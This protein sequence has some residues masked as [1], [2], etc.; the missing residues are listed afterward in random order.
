MGK[1]KK[2]P[3]V[4]FKGFSDE[5]EEK[6]IG[7][8]VTEKKRSVELLDDE[9]YELIKVK[10]RNEGVISRGYLKGKDILV[11]NYSQLKAGD[12]IISKR[13][14]VHG[15]TGIVPQELDKAIV[16]NEYL[17][18]GSNEYISTE[19]LT[20]I[21]TLPEMYRKFFLSSYGVDIEKLFFDADDWKKRRVIIPKPSEQK[22]ICSWFRRL[23]QMIKLHQ[24][25]HEKLMSLKKAMLQKMFPQNGATVPEVRF[26]GFS[27][28]WVEKKLGQVGKTQSGIG[29]PEPEQGGKDGLPFFKISDMGNHGNEHVMKNAKNYVNKE[30]VARKRWNPITQVP[31]II[32]AKVG[33]A[34]LLNRKRMVQSP[35]LID[36]NTM[37]YLFDKSWDSNFGRA[38]F[39]TIYLPKYAQ[40]GALPSYNGTFIENIDIQVP[41]EKL[42]QKKIGAYLWQLD[43]LIMQHG[44]QV[45]K[46]KQ[47]K[48]ACLTKMF[49]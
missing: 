26:K 34:I 16:S 2:S 14:V 39:N 8:V 17:V 25:K 32:F 20:L 37:A 35:F 42:E 38:L 24:Q 3:V 31:A 40:V 43:E 48:A 47:I 22:R 33:A 21:S 12:Y 45:K 28:P 11:K 49:V 30:Q 23:D 5:W 1:K 36:N 15:A 18:A 41:K 10:R 4:R 6:R 19:F 13:Q 29:F 46:L 9:L 27:G 44:I 7:E